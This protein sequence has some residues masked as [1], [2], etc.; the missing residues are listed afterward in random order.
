MLIGLKS[1]LLDRPKKFDPIATT[2]LKLVQI[3]VKYLS[4]NK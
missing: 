4:T 2:N 3:H 1:S